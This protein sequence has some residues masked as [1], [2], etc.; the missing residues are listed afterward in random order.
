M[1]INPGQEAQPLPGSDRTSNQS[2]AGNDNRAAVGSALGEDQAQLSGGHAQVQALAAQVAQFPEVRQEK[3]SALRQ[4]VLDGSY[5]RS[6]TQVAG[7][8]FE[9]MVVMPAA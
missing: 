8:L 3:V 1:R 6:S 5:Q 7:A 4:V 9:H 2:P